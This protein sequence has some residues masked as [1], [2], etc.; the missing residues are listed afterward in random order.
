MSSDA[1]VFSLFLKASPSHIC[2]EPP[3]Q[4]G[5][6][7]VDSVLIG[8]LRLCASQYSHDEDRYED[9]IK[10]LNKKLKEVRKPLLAFGKTPNFLSVALHT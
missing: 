7:N 3:E 4:A 6:Q 5:R 8:R 9:E 10:N 2:Q 1:S